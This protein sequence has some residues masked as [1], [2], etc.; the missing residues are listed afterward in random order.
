MKNQIFLINL[1]IKIKKTST[2]LTS[3]LIKNFNFL[4]KPNKYKNKTKINNIYNKFKKTN[5]IKL[6]NIEKPI[7]FINFKIKTKNNNFIFFHNNLH[8]KFLL[9]IINKN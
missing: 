3:K 5:K 6:N 9:K 7:H 4:K 1:I 8:L 2:K